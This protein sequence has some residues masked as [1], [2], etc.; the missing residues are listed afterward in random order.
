MAGET[1]LIFACGERAPP[2]VV[3]ALA[4]EAGAIIACD[5]ALTTCLEHGLRPDAV[6]GD[7]DSVEQDQLDEHVARGGTVVE[8]PQQNANDLSKAIDWVHE[9]GFTACWVVGATG[10]DPQHEW[11]N[12]L[13]CGASSLRI[14]CISHTHVYRFFSPGGSYSIEIEPGDEFSLFAL[15]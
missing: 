8:R 2:A 10:G 6:V 11:A 14:T 12:L 1:A 15:P 9:Q 13:A 5:G 3:L 7:M 4:G